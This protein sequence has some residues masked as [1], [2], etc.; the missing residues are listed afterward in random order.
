MFKMK[1]SSQFRWPVKFQWPDNGKFIDRQFDATF[2][3]VHTDDINRASREIAAGDALSQIAQFLDGVVIAVHDVDLTDAADQPITD[4]E[5]VRQA[6][7]GDP[8]ISLA[9]Y[10]AYT[11]AIAGGADREAGRKN[12]SAP[13]ST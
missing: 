2:R 10:R 1:Q 13:R 8:T 4:P 11:E 12:S 9:M 5:L 3:R 7:I 6:M